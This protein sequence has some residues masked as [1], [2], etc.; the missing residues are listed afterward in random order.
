MGST[1]RTTSNV[2]IMTNKI[3]PEKELLNILI[4][5]DSL[6]DKE[7]IIEQLTTAGYQLNVTHSINESSFNNALEK[8]HYDIIL[9]DFKLPGFDA[10]G[11]LEICQKKCPEVPFICVSGSIGE[12][13]A[14]E[15]LKK[16]AVDYV[17]K[18]RP[19]RLPHA[20]KRALEEVKE[21]HALLN[22]ERELLESEARF[23]QV[24]ETAQEWIW[25]VD[26]EGLYIY[27]SPL[28]ETLLGY[29]SGEVV[30]KKHF[31]DFFI[32]EEKEI[33]KNAAFEIFAKRE[34]FRNFENTNLRKDGQLVILST[35]GSPVFDSSGNLKGYRGVDGDITELKQAEKNFRH[36][37]DQSPLGIRIVNQ[38]GITIY[39]N[40]AF[41]DIYDFAN[42]DEYVNTPAIEKYTEQSY[43]EHLQRKKFRK[44]GRDV[45][46]YEISIR[47]KNGRIRHVKVWRKEVVWNKEKHFQVINQDI[48]EEKTLYNDLFLAK[49]RAEESDRLK[50]A[51]LANLSHEIRTPMNG[52]LGFMGLLK[53]P[54]LSEETKNDYIDIVNKS[55]NRLMN[56]I[57]DII[58][59]SKIDARQVT[60][61]KT[62]FCIV[63]LLRELVDFFRPEAA[64]KGLTIKYRLPE[65]PLEI[66]SDK[67]KFESIFTNLIKNAIKFTDSGEINIILEQISGRLIASVSDTGIGISADKQ[68]KIF[69][70]FVQNDTG[71]GR[72]YEGTGLGLCITREY[73]KLL[74]GNIRVQSEVNKG[75][76][77]YVELPEQEMYISYDNSPQPE[78]Q[79]TVLPKTHRKKTILIAEDD[80][81]SFQYLSVLLKNE[82][83]EIL[84][85]R[86]GLQAVE[87]AVEKDID[88]VLMDAKM[89][90]L[91][92]YLAT[93]EILKAKPG[94]PIIMQTAFALAD[95]R[96]KAINAGCVD[97]L[98][99]PIRKIQLHTLL[100]K[101]A[102]D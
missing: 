64:A 19:E 93:M 80:D 53:E 11:A 47:R 1:E 70:R 52:I 35:S 20:I 61:E 96:E 33:L 38:Q 54:D 81:I 88:L 72:T 57:N 94:L 95:D 79:N 49:E 73:V 36:S 45:T 14:I 34:I 30:G 12:E 2:L 3:Y 8:S 68:E 69:E 82:K 84:W 24:A 10:F 42:V 18:D 74:N 78:L 23:R 63:R 71:L 43:R 59:I 67:G 86:D 46:S 83:M 26:T 99:K 55:G 65:Q 28:V 9:S 29:T 37:I 98:S 17:L 41:L 48:T 92:G 100:Q 76:T 60:L 102:G 39:A 16:G 85:A 27:S 90:Y 31:Y 21:K 66:N 56:T 91:N 101:Y 62:R 15:I 5:E 87:L 44:S 51:F 77:F 32:P 50:S 6:S 75:T 13:K 40:Q 58:E 7:L 25:E 97:Y 4:L 89:P 22:A